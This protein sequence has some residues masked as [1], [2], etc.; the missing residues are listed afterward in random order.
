MSQS[1]YTL[2]VFAAAA[3]L[4]ALRCLQ[5]QQPPKTVEL[6]LVEPR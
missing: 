1:G 4:A 5:T 6:D 3:A 2:P